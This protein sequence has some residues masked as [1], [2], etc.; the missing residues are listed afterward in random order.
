MY[1]VPNA[2]TSG[3]DSMDDSNPGPSMGG[4]SVGSH[5]VPEGFGMPKHRRE[6]HE[7]EETNGGEDYNKNRNTS[8]STGSA[9][10]TITRSSTAATSVASN[11][12]PSGTTQASASASPLLW[13]LL[14]RNLVKRYMNKLWTN[15]Y[16]SSKRQ[17][18]EG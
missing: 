7:S 6:Q 12:S 15:S 4:R 14:R 11:R 8:S 1:R 10:T 3:K 5:D 17:Q 2:Y 13:L 9:P 16:R 18:L